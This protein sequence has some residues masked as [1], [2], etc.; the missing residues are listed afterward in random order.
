MLKQCG[1]Q[2]L[3]DE[4][5]KVMAIWSKYENLIPSETKAYLNDVDMI[6]K[7]YIS[8]PLQAL[9]K[10][11]L[12]RLVP[13]LGG[14]A[15]LAAKLARYLRTGQSTPDP[16]NFPY[17]LVPVAAQLAFA[18]AGS[19]A[20]VADNIQKRALDFTALITRPTFLAAAPSNE[21]LL[22]KL[23]KDLAQAM[24]AFA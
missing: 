22:R 5:A 21:D 19:D 23:S 1:V 18:Q 8:K 20:D 11:P 13:D 14:D 9:K 16:A 2:S 15:D 10:K 12:S 24:E 7:L 3:A 6:A 4:A 17:R